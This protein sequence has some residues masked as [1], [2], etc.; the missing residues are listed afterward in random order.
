VKILDPKGRDVSGPDAI[1]D[2]DG[3]VDTQYRGLKGV[4]KDTLWVK[5]AGTTPAGKYTVVV[6]TRYQRYIGDYV[7]H[8]H[9]LDHEDQG[10]MQHIRVSLPD[11]V[12]GTSQGHQH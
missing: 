9:I 6:R 3:T 5:N 12:G 2:A 7:L 1:D 10:M 8:C 11:G 4:W